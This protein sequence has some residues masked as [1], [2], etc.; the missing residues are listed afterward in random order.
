MLAAR[1]QR[2]SLSTF[3]PLMTWPRRFEG[4]PSVITACNSQ[5]LETPKQEAFFRQGLV[6]GHSRNRGPVICNDAEQ[7]FN[8]GQQSV[9]YA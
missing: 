2:R 5:E 7:Q 6:G 1:K 9:E 3:I 4:V 8:N